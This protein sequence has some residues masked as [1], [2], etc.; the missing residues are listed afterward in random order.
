[1]VLAIGGGAAAQGIGTAEYELKYAREYYSS[2]EYD[3]AAMR[4]RQ[5]LGLDPEN[6]EAKAL[7]IDAEAKAQAKARARAAAQATGTTRRSSAASNGSRATRP[8]SSDS[9]Q[10]AFAI[11]WTAANRAGDYARQNACFTQRNQCQARSR[12]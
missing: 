4:A 10:A 8:A 12:H 3:L 7:V 9:C 11:C 6:E 1:M 5:A 2:G